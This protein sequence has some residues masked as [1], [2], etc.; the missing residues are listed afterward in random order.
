MITS[1]YEQQTWSFYNKAL[2]WYEPCT[3]LGIMEGEVCILKAYIL[4]S[5]KQAFKILVI[6]PKVDEKQYFIFMQLV[7]VKN[8]LDP[9]LSGSFKIIDF[10]LQ[11]YILHVSIVSHATLKSYC[12]LKRN[13][14]ANFTFL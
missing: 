1:S 8:T 4:E 11:L 12:I 13:F 3:Y 9:F 7:Y 14:E 5:H 2:V 10:F 6:R